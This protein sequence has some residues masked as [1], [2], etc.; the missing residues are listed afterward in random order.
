MIETWKVLR[1][2]KPEHF[3]DAFNLFLTSSVG[4]LMPLW[5]LLILLPLSNQAINFYAFTKNGELAL[6][7][8]SF[9]SAALYALAKEY[10][11]HSQEINIQENKSQTKKTFP[12][13]SM[14][15]VSFV[16]II[17]ATSLIFS[18]VT[19]ANMP[20]STSELNIDYLI[21]ASLIVFLASLGLS[22]I[23]AVIDNY[24]STYQVEEEIRISRAQDLDDVTEKFESLG[25]E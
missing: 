19:Q 23:S 11:K 22:Y 15:Q 17:A 1:S 6:Y 8:A 7:A 3:K 20:N 5:G 12:A 24:L 21:Q 10:T 25:E 18:Y 2:C 16:G 9:A 13:K 14:F 4:G